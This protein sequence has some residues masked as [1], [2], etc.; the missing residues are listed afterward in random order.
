MDR[1]D[2]LDKA[3]R[4]GAPLYSTNGS[5]VECEKSPPCMTAA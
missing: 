3:L 2:R 5:F 1:F 4:W